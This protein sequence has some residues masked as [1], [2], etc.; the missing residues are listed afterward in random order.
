[1]NGKIYDPIIHQMTGPDILDA[2]PY[3]TQAYNRYAYAFNNPMSFTDPSGFVNVG[4][5]AN[6]PQGIGEP[7]ISYN[8]LDADFDWMTMQTMGAYNPFFDNPFWSLIFGNHVGLETSISDSDVTFTMDT[9]TRNGSGDKMEDN[10]TD[11]KSTDDFS[12]GFGVKKTLDFGSSPYFGFGVQT[13]GTFGDDFI[14]GLG[15][16]GLGANRILGPAASA[17]GIYTFN[18]AANSNISD[19]RLFYISL[20]HLCL[21]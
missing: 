2:N 11:K 5:I 3:S 18:S 9:E 10:H 21:L 19:V 13:F 8:N 17:Y 6:R 12:F 16:F 15:R 4:N 1:M 14:R 20:K 7:A